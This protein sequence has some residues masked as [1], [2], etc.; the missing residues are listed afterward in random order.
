MYQQSPCNSVQ[1]P[2]TAF[3]P[4]IS[5]GAKHQK[6]MNTQLMSELKKGN[7]TSWMMTLGSPL[8]CSGESPELCWLND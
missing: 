2:M 7:W 8:W 4:V 3:Q 6:F 1:T 5:S